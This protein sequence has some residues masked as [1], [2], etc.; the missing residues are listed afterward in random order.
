MFAGFAT[1]PRADLFRMG[2][3]H[4]IDHRRSG[5]ILS[6]PAG[7]TPFTMVSKFDNVFLDVSASLDVISIDGL[8]LKINY[9]DRL[10]EHTE[11]H[12]GGAKLGVN[13]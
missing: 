13:F 12:V 8:T 3:G 2:L 7:V 9:D 1:A 4:A 11:S 10:A 6:A 5:G